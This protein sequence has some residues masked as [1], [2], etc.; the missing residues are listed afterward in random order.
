VTLK[1]LFILALFFFTAP[2]I[3]HALAQAC[4]HDNVRP[5]LAEDR[6]GRTAGAATGEGSA[7]RPS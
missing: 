5:L 1:L 3:T 4:L 7:G 2:V 6:R